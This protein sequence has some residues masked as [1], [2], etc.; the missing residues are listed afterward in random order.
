[1]VYSKKKIFVSA[2][3][4]FAGAALVLVA[5]FFYAKRESG[6]DDNTFKM[7]HDGSERYYKIHRPEGYDGK[8]KLPM[9]IYLHGG[10]GD[11]RSA[12]L[13]GL[14]KMADKHN[15]ILAAPEG[16]G[17]KK[18]GRLRAHWNGGGWETGGCCGSADDTGFIAK[19]IE[20]IKMKYE[21]DKKRIFVTGISNG[22]L[23]ANRLACELGD[24]IAAIG[25][26]APPAI[27]SDCLPDRAVPVINIHGLQDPASPP[28]G[29]EPRSIFAADSGSGFAMTYKRMTPAQI[30]D[31]WK[32]INRCAENKTTGY[33]SGGASCETYGDC[34]DGAEVELCIV[35]GMGHTYPGGN[36]YLP[37]NLVGPVTQDI[38]FD[39][40]WEFFTKHSLD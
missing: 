36:Q 11:M 22:A 32:T 30:I 12:Y 29:S 40:I 14:D 25:A 24:K 20:E 31:K 19:M 10:G 35:D 26:V 9:V 13:D 4:V 5:M 18:L 7:S 23:M 33:R 1:M 8:R 39:Q 21:I 34:A 6:G 27:K 16:L 2:V 15:F 28:D 37:E 38:T 17:E 3:V